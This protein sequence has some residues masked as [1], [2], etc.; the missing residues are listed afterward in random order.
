MGVRG[1]RCVYSRRPGMGIEGFCGNGG[2]QM[3]G[4]GLEWV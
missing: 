1:F 3:T 4:N 2:R